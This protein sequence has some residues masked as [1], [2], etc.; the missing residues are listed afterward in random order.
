[1]SLNVIDVNHISIS[2]IFYKVNFVPVDPC[3][4]SEKRKF[5]RRSMSLN[6][7]DVIDIST[8]KFFYKVDLI[9]GDPCFSSEK[10]KLIFSVYIKYVASGT[11]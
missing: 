3:F 10:R 5:S 7:V 1:M 2:K 11:M 9:P 4:S 6:V 8:S